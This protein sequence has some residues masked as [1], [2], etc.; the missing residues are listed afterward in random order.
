MSHL[1]SIH[2]SQLEQFEWEMDL[3]GLFI[4]VQHLNSNRKVCRTVDGL[5][6][7]ILSLVDHLI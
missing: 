3:E 2:F 5:F 4:A 1:N 6:V 7:L